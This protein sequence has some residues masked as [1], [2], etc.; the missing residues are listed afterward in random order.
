MYS[1]WK[2]FKKDLPALFIFFERPLLALLFG[3]DVY[4]LMSFY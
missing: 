4:E 3:Q 2:Q 1:D